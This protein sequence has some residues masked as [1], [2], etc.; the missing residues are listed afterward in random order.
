MSK[1]VTSLQVKFTEK[2]VFFKLEMDFIK[3]LSVKI[4]ENFATKMENR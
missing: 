4:S 2:C 3:Y 1:H